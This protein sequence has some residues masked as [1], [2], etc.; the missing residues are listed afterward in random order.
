MVDQQINVIDIIFGRW[1]SQVLYASV[2]LGVFDALGRE[3]KDATRLAEELG[4]NAP[5]LYRLLRALGSLGLLREEPNRRFSMSPAG[6]V[7]R[8]DHPNT[9]RGV[10]L[11]E[12]G[13]EHYALWKHLPDM[14]REGRQDA[15]IRE[16]GHT[17]LE[18]LATHLEYAQA[19]DQA[20]S[21]YSG[22]ET[23][24]VLEALDSYDFSKIS[25]LCVLGGGRGH[26]LCSFLAKYRHLK[27]TVF[28]RGEVIEDRSLL[29]ADKM[30]V[31]DRCIYVAGDMLTE[32]PATDAYLMKHVQHGFSDE[33]CV[34]VLRNMSRA[35]PEG[36]RVFIAEYV[37]PGPETPHFSKFFDIH[38]M[39][40][41]PGRERTGEEYASLLRRAGWEYVDIWPAA[42]GAMSVVEGV[43]V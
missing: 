26:L 35:A 14:V 1:R 13:P 8:A 5:L 21:S 11:L 24:W 40:W 34:K 39:C 29:W 15:F 20:M 27:G 32:V 18:H 4:L 10:T 42:A 43:K 25:H 9:L 2:K 30:G 16:F 36:A 33:E 6:E 12:E 3:A 17:G 28:E 23:A 38:M 22:T 7:L 41:G 19:F 37:V 31:G